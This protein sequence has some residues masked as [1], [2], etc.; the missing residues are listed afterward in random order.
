MKEH[1]R[2]VA[3]RMSRILPLRWRTRDAFQREKQ[4]TRASKMGCSAGGK[5]LQSVLLLARHERRSPAYGVA[6][7]IR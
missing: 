4:Y 6:Q 3:Q 2:K 1:A 5:V 7:Y